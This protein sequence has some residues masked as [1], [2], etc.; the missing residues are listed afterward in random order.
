M[1]KKKVTADRQD[2]DPGRPGVAR[3]ARRHRARPP[4]RGDH[5]LLQGVQRP[6]RV[7]ARHDHPRRDLDLRGPHVLVRHQD[8]AGPGADPSGRRRS[9]RA[10]RRRAR[11]AP[12]AR[13]PTSSSPRSRRSSCPTSTPTTSSMAKLQIAGTARSM[14][15]RGPAADAR[16]HRHQHRSHT[17]ARG[18]RPRPGA[19]PHEGA[20][21]AKGKKYLDATKRFDR[22]Q[23]TRARRGDRSGQVAVEPQLRRDRRGRDPLGRR[24]PQGRPDGPRHRR[25]ARR[26]PART[27]ASRC[28]PPATPP[29]RPRPPGPTSSAPTT[30]PSA[31]RA[32]SSTSTSRS[33][34]PTSCRSSVSLG[35]VLG[36]RGLMPNPKTG[37]VTTDVGKAVDRL[38]GRQG[39]VPHRPP[40][41]RA[42]AARQGQLRG[43]CAR[44]RTSPPIFDELNRARAG[45]GQGPL[46]PQGHRV[47]DHGPRHQG[48][49][50]AVRDL[51][52]LGLI[53]VWSCGATAL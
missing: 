31:S 15:I 19:R 30:S 5:G 41:Q 18:E 22:E 20:I 16:R 21:M 52:G 39:R 25:A 23:L 38:Q 51:I 43:R 11:A 46:H 2:P 37:T 48:R 49:C 10:A 44:P 47:L 4:R 34:R 26:A 35:R 6:H 9:T 50:P 8:P 24:S 53:Q 17:S 33:P 14:G 13:S 32:A 3:A 40:R 27:S 29:V 45:L 1:A 12:S 28:S 36:P 42:R 7:P